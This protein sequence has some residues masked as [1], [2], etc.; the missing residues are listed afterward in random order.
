MSLDKINYIGNAY[1]NNQA[2]N[3]RYMNFLSMIYITFL[4]AAT[5]MAYKVVNI[6]GVSEPGSTLIYT[7]TF[8]LGNIYAELYGSYFAKKLIWQSVIT[9]YIFAILISVVN[10]LPSP[11]YWNLGR[12]FDLVIGHVLR[13]T[14][15]GII[16]YLS[17]AFLNIYLL[18][19][20]KDKLKGRYFWFRSL[21]ATTISEG[22][23]T[24]IAGIITFIGMMPVKNIFAVMLNA[25]LFKMIYGLIAVWPASFVVHMLKAREVKLKE[26]KN[27]FKFSYKLKKFLD[28]SK[29]ANT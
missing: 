21:F 2:Q 16:G 17:S 14:T 15:A 26:D 4:M 6:G 3:F 10:A 23:A 12:E 5:V 19:K 13:F 18:T 25:F 24:F 9:G 11:L 27:K 7:F 28:S 1:T 20:W 8:F 22:A 29:V